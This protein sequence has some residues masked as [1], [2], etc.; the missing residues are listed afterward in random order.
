MVDGFE[1]QS[2]T[3]NAAIEQEATMHL[4]LI[5]VSQE[6]SFVNDQQFRQR[7]SGV[8]RGTDLSINKDNEKEQEDEANIESLYLVTDINEES[9]KYRFSL[10]DYFTLTADRSQSL[11]AAMVTQEYRLKRKWAQELCKKPQQKED[12]YGLI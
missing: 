2:N 7:K 6:S 3:N 11:T 4:Q 10:N 5:D 12:D 9:S 1:E 8:I